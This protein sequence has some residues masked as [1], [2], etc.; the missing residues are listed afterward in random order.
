MADTLTQPE[1]TQLIKDYLKSFNAKIDTKSTGTY[2]DV[3]YI[4]SRSTLI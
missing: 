4:I 2:Y 3:R 1:L